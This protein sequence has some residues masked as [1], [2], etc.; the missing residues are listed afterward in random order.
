[1]PPT[2]SLAAP[3][4]AGI[5][6]EPEI[7]R[8]LPQ[9]PDTPASLLAPVPAPGPLPPDAE[10]PYFRLDPLLDPPELPQP[11]WFFNLEV[12]PTKAHIKNDL[13]TTV[14]NPAT[15]YSDQ[16]GLPSATLDWSISPRFEAG[17]RLSSGFG[18]FVLSYRFL[19]TQ[20]HDLYQNSDGPGQLSSLLDINQV[21]LDYA[22]SEFS[23]WPKW[24][25]RWR[26][27]LRYADVYFDS[28]AAEGFDEAAAGSG[29]FQT[30]V[31]NS[32]VGFGPHAGMDL[33]RH[34]G[35]GGLAFVTRADFALLVGH[36]RQQFSE[37]TT[38][39]GPD[40]QPLVG[41]LG[42][43]DSQG[44][45]VLEVQAGLSW[46]P[47][48]YPLA[49]FFLGY[50]YEYWWEVGMLDNINNGNGTFGEVFDQG[51]VLRAEFS[52]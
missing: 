14:L 33:S 28:R 16:V 37:R 23:L 3:R 21:D 51:V 47:P 35:T 11:G 5:A 46:Q 41:A 9:V 52:F 13:R 38:T 19:A 18:E 12:D 44:V 20:G 25:M 48:R 49:T 39:F 7:L 15:G 50:R 6:S 2:G 45:P 29:V 30:R 42:A 24:D 34:F 10:R 43:S 1:V 17:Y 4:E 8:S 32:F 40:G 27:G 26:L 36:I 22:S 31:T